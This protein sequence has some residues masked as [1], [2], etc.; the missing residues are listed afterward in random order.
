MGN[1]NE[2]TYV[3]PKN[4]DNNI[5]NNNQ[6]NNNIKSNNTKNIFLKSIESLVK[7]YNCI[8]Y[9]FD[10]KNKN[11]QNLINKINNLKQIIKSKNKTFLLISDF[12]YDEIININL[13]IEKENYI[14]PFNYDIKYGN[15]Y[16]LPI[17]EINKNMIDFKIPLDKI[18][19]DISNQYGF[20][21]EKIILLSN[22]GNLTNLELKIGL[23]YFE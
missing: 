9:Y 6:I 21:Y 23:A 16:K 3:K 20:D 17:G 8:I 14:S 19:E 4:I 7:N 5:D 18:I 22:I 13:I 10:I 15:I 2:G 11:N 12:R 1:I